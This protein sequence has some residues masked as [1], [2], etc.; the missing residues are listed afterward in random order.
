MK[1]VTLCGIQ[2]SGKTTFIRWMIARFRSMGKQ[3]A[4][5]VNESGKEDYD[6]DFAQTHQLRIERLR[7]G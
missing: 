3:S 2:E 6:K 5:I 7:G 1:V 4:V